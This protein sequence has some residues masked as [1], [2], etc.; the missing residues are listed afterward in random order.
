MFKIFGLFISWY[1]KDATLSILG[2]WRNFI[3]FVANYFSIVLL[4][5]TLFNPW[6]RISESYG[7]GFDIGKFF[8]ALTLNVLSRSIGFIMRSAAIFMGVLA[9]IFVLIFGAAFLILWFFLPLI[10]IWTLFYGIILL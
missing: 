7:R 5:K 8:S 10:L 6:K 1:F 2:I 9:E 4:F 3:L